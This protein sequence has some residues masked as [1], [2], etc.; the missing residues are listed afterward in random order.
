MGI[1]DFLR[2]RQEDA[3]GRKI[4][5]KIRDFQAAKATVDKGLSFRELGHFGE[6]IQLLEQAVREFS[7]YSPG[8]SVLGNTYRLAGRLDDAEKIWRRG[9]AEHSGDGVCIELLANLGSLYYFDRGDKTTA[10]SLYQQA[11]EYQSKDRDD[12]KTRAA[13]ISAIHRDLCLL[14]M[15]ENQSQLAKEHALER[16]ALRDGCPVASKILAMCIVNDYTA[17]GRYA[18]IMQDSTECPDLIDAVSRAELAL[19]NNKE[20]YASMSTAALAALYLSQSRFYREKGLSEGY[21]QMAETLSGRL[22][23]AS[24]LSEE[25]AR[26]DKFY[27]DR[28]AKV[29]EATLRS[30]GHNVT[31]KF[32]E[33]ETGR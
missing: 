3:D 14:Y 7:F 32:E 6:A 17:T 20:D 33:P 25:A 26:Y 24:K 11:L 23:E 29:M 2:R 4:F 21:E 8:K 18:A 1:F 22:E 5:E 15:H 28:F 16:L 9:L 31:V 27:S 13:A 10:L 12:E 30:L 19:R